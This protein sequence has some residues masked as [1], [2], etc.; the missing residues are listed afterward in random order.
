VQ[1]T[2]DLAR[3]VLG[4]DT[5]FLSVVGD[6]R[7][8]VLW[9]VGNGAFPQTVPGAS[10][11]LDE[12]ICRHLLEGRIGELVPDV[13]A[14]PVLCD[15][16]LPRAAGV[17]AYMGV[18]LTGADARQYILCCLA[19]EARPDLGEADVRFLRGL[20]ESLVLSGALDR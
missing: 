7:E 19:R 13:A 14:D 6:H 2:L 9:A 15:L 20:T 11:E 16:P 5:A 1:R 3:T 12:T 10:V 17:G 18:P 4:V 8:T